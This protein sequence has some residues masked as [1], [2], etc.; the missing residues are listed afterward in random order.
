MA[1]SRTDDPFKGRILSVTHRMDG[2]SHITLDNGATD[3]VRLVL[4]S[5]EYGI[6]QLQDTREILDKLM[7]PVPGSRNKPKHQGKGHKRV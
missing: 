5:Q 4:P 2:L 3:T 1:A 7:N 6:F